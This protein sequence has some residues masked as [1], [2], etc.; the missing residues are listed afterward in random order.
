M[1]A[2]H[3]PVSVIFLFRSLRIRYKLDSPHY[4]HLS[5]VAFF[6]STT[7]SGDRV[8]PSIHTSAVKVGVS[9]L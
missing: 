3:N 2:R 7:T 9:G 4:D 8:V 5:A 6:E 1:T